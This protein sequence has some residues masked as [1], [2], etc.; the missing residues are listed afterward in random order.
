[1][2]MLLSVPQDSVKG[3]PHHARAIR[4]QRWAVDSV[5][6][7]ASKVRADGDAPTPVA[8]AFGAYRPA[9]VSSPFRQGHLSLLPGY[10]RRHR[11]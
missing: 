6:C 8:A 5:S 1:M 2:V 4:R 7:A 3:S 11:R 10:R 9:D